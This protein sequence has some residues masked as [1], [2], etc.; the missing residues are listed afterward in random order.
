MK[1]MRGKFT[2]RMMI[3]H[4]ITT[5]KQAMHF[6]EKFLLQGQKTKNQFSS[7]INHLSALFRTKVKKHDLAFLWDNFGPTHCDRVEAV[8]QAFAGDLRCIGVEE[9]SRSDTYDWLPEK[10]DGFEKV[11][12]F[13][14]AW[15]GTIRMLIALIKQ[16]IKIGKAT[17]FLCNY[18]RL[19]IF[20]FAVWLRIRMRKVFLMADSKF[21]DIKRNLF[22]EIL[23]SFVLWPYRGAISCGYRSK[24]Y[25]RF[26]L[27]KNK[28]VVG[29]YDTLSIS[30]IRY[31]SNSP[32]APN[33]IPFSSRDWI[34]VAR[35]IEEKNIQVALDGFA[36]Y[37]EI[38]SRKRR[39]KI[40]GSGP[41]EAKLKLYADQLGISDMVDF[42]GFVQTEEI[43]KHLAR[44]CALILPSIQ[45]TF[46][47]VVIEAQAMGLPV[48]ISEV[49][50]ARDHLVRNWVN[51]FVFEPDNATA[52]AYYMEL[53]DRDEAL[54]R[55]LCEGATATAPLG[56]VE[57]FVEGVTALIGGG[58]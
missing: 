12:L 36:K 31:L 21:D 2:A 14:P 51:G 46:G 29:E 57:R 28:S 43:C 10:R 44:S 13:G 19:H 32:P 16:D 22:R 18:N 42:V 3:Y 52:L 48:L 30:R 56:D 39:L 1:N 4:L 34:I 47:L 27:G 24:S 8:M 38:S 9:R 5:T 55:R 50:G 23:K 33:G 11:T 54:W 41:L 20:L 53:L 58:R 6:F 45:E 35:L 40:C 25:M 17:W 49:P 26:L 15:P 37:L 7:L